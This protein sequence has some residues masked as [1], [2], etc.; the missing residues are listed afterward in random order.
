MLHIGC[1]LSSSKGFAAMGR[2]AL[3]IGADT[4]AFFHPQSPGQQGQ[5]DRSGRR[6]RLSGTVG[7]QPGRPLV[8][9][10]PYTLNPCSSKPNVR[11]FARETLA[12]DLRKM[13]ALPG[14]YYNM[15]PGNHLGQGSQTGIVL[16]GEILNQIIDPAMHTTLLLETMAG[17][18]HGNGPEF[19]GTAG[20]PGPAGTSGKS[21]NLP[22]Y[23]PRLGR[24]LRYRP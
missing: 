3:S 12:D 22:G 21:G 4:F 20:H 23:L 13:E 10:A 1:H 17:K 6:G 14:N 24:W 7:T 2:T 9:H 15:H 11:E 16:I 18:G 8:A 19:R 5:G